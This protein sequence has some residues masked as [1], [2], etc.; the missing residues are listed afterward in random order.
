MVDQN[1]KYVGISSN[2]PVRVRVEDAHPQ[3]PGYF[4]HMNPD[5]EIPLI[6]VEHKKNGTTGPWG[7]GDPTNKTTIPQ[8]LLK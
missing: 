1:G 4:G 7:K 8:N 6:H 2:G 5:N 3:E